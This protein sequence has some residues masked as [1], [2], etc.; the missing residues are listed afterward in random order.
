METHSHFTAHSENV[1]SW[2]EH[3]LSKVAVVNNSYN[4]DTVLPDDISF[5][6]LSKSISCIM[7]SFKISNPK[8]LIVMQNLVSA[9]VLSQT[10]DSLNPSSFSNPQLHFGNWFI[11]TSG[12]MAWSNQDG[13]LF[14]YFPF[15]G[16]SLKMASCVIYLHSYRLTGMCSSCSPLISNL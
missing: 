15:S 10:G 8:I 4:L 12:Q 14:S 11:I 1:S 9:Q 2:I 3:R 7:G 5:S 13:F 16:C 6:F